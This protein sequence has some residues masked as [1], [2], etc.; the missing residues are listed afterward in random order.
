MS[1]QGAIFLAKDIEGG[2]QAS[3]HIMKITLEANGI[4]VTPQIEQKISLYFKMRQEEYDKKVFAQGVP[5]KLQTLLNYTKKSKLLAY[6][7]RIT[8][9]EEELFL[10]VH[11]CSQIGYTHQ[12]KFL[13]YV[14]ENRRL[15]ES[16]RTVLIKNEPKKFFGKIRALF[17]ERKNYMVHLF[18]SDKIWHLFYYTYHEMEADKNKWKHGPH[19]HFVN[20][21]WPEYTK[22]KVWE[23]FDKRE[24]NINGV[25]IRLKPIPE[26]KA[27]GNQEFRAL[28]HALI[29]KYKQS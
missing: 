25:H 9:T 18:E 19:L 13:E 24:H 10:L 12:S 28:A 15:T 6:C 23:S 14:P 29:A 4:V 20:Y 26:Y 2:I 27:E 16:D 7:R 3:T 8:I 21:L 11:N 22:R 17:K 1:K 5:E